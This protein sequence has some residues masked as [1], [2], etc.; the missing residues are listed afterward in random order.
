MDLFDS[1]NDASENL[2]PCDGC[3][4]YHGRVISFEV[5][6]RYLAALR[7][8]IDWENDTLVIYGKQIVTKRKVAWYG[9]H[10]FRYG[11][12]RTTKVALPWA[13]DLLKL[14][15]IVERE[16]REMYNSC[17][18]NLYH[19]GSEGMGW[20]SDAEKELKRDG[21]IA[22]LSLGAERR[23][24]FKHKR[25]GQIVEKLLQHG[26]LLVMKGA[27]QTHWQ[28]RLPPIAGVSAARINLTFR[29]FGDG[30]KG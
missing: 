11:Y 21:A 30:S 28:H 19:D 13:K 24:V 14:K 26:S 29:M 23:F 25:T 16:T 10:A 20:H 27:T 22:S 3:V 17:L 8:N 2:L 15:D 4:N 5:A 1:L 7:K 6:D 12:S 9:D 18:L